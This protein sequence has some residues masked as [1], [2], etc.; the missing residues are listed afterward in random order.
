MA[1]ELIEM[2]IFGLVKYIVKLFKD[3]RGRLSLIEVLEK[4][5]RLDIVVC[6][7]SEVCN[8]VY[9]YQMKFGGVV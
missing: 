2:C 6:S 3:D 8:V 1:Q 7:R 4:Y 5:H 9:T